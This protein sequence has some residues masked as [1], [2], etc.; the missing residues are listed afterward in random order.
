MPTDTHPVDG[1]LGAPGRPE[2]S[3]PRRVLVGAFALAL[4]AAGIAFAA[5]ALR[6]DNSPK[7][8]AT[9]SPSVE[10]SPVPPLTGD[11]RITAEIPLVDDQRNGGTG[12][13]AVGAG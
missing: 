10:T 7:A 2:P 1:R 4:A 9:L 11:P 3:F 5:R 12:G 13:V 6:P 8:E